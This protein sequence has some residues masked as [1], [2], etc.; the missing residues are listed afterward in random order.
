MG[1]EETKLSKKI[2]RIMIGICIVMIAIPVAVN[3]MMFISIPTTMELTDKE[4]LSFWGS[5]LG[6]C[7]GG[8]CTLITIFMTI[9]FYEEQ[10]RI[11]KEELEKQNKIH[12]KEMKDA[13]LQK[14][15]PLL[16]INAEG[17]NGI[18]G[19]YNP[20]Y[21]CVKNVSE[22]SAVNVIIENKYKEIIGKNEEQRY[23]ITSENKDGGYNKYL[24]VSTNDVLGNKYS[25]TYELKK[26]DDISNENGDKIEHYY[27]KILQE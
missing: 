8:I 25:W 20:F 12:E 16:V 19:R 10:E 15:R 2:K 13:N 26:V 18:Q 5:Y 27:Y 3:T 11:H 22:Y 17:G 24:E 23:E 9:R 7:L 4:W 21:I 6:G 14:Y 1:K